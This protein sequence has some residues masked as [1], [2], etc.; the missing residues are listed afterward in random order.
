[1]SVLKKVRNWLA[2]QGT[3]DRNS[4]VWHLTSEDYNTLFSLFLTPGF[5]A[6]KLKQILTNILLM[7]FTQI[8]L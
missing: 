7:P 3:I 1:M 4:N 2:E 6:E 5:P 8:R